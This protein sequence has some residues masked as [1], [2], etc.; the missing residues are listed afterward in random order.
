MTYKSNDSI[1]SSIKEAMPN[2]GVPV[3]YLA[4]DQ[5]L[6]MDINMILVSLSQIGVGKI[7]DV[8]QISGSGEI[9][10][11]FLDDDELMSLV[12][13]YVAIKVRLLFDPVK[14]SIVRE[15]LLESAKELEFRIGDAC[16][17][18]HRRKGDVM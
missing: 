12:P 15:Q 6:I 5:E 3:D 16:R 4:F 7:G 2:S 8:F 11:D 17:R 1:L 10:S 18:Y 9:W 14:S 13:V